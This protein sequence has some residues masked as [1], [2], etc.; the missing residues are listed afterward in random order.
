MEAPTKTTP[1]DRMTTTA[2]FV[3]EIR[4]VAW[5]RDEAKRRGVNKSE[6]VRDLID[7]AI[8]DDQPTERAA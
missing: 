3:V 1:L 6:L 4:H 7:R 2:S 5:I 8:A